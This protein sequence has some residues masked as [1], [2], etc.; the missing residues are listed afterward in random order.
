MTEIQHTNDIGTRI[1]VDDGEYEVW[2]GPASELK[3][4]YISNAFIAGMGQTRNQAVAD[5]VRKLEAV[6][7]AL[8]S[9]PD[10]QLEGQ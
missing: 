4:D 3:A 8:Q 2:V 7:D 9:P 6:I 10:H 5:A 1:Y